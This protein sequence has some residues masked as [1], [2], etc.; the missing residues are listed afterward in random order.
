MTKQKKNGKCIKKMT[1]MEIY[2][3]TSTLERHKDGDRFT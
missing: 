3:S 1:L 2:Y